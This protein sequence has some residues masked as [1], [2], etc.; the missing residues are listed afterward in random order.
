MVSV[1]DESTVRVKLV[2]EELRRYREMAGF[3]QSQAADRLGF[4]KSKVSRM[5]SGSRGQK[6]EDVAGLLAIYGVRGAERQQVLDLTKAV[7][8]PGFW[9]RTS[10]LTHRIAILKVLESRAIKLINFEC[11]VIPGL[12][13]TVPYI[14]AL[15]RNV[16]LVDEELIGERVAARVHRQSVLRRSGAPHLLAIV[17][18]QALRNLVGD[19]EIMR[20][21]LVYLTEVARHR[22]VSLRVVPASAG[23]HPGFDGPFMRLQ[24]HNRRGVVVLANRTS[25]LYLEDD[26]DL[27]AY[28]NVLVELLS[29]ALSE[30][31]SVAL[32]GDIEAGLA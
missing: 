7:D 1:L 12:L 10:S 20:E 27:F 23:N 24:F 15:M 32:V 21:Q 2:G 28:G 29:V 31:D 17:A 18:E 22:H 30:E 9:Q 19:P 26:E 16:G 13:Q 3:T 14:E 11:S 25:S 8:E 6:C 5:E 4:E